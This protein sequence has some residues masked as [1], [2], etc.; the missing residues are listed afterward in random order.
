MQRRVIS[1]ALFA[2]GTAAAL[3]PGASCG[4]ASVVPPVRA[5]HETQGAVDVRWYGAV[6]DGA[7]D[8]TDAVA[9]ALA[10]ASKAGLTLV[11][12]AGFTFRITRYLE[13][14]SNTNLYLLGTIRLTNRVAGLYANGATNIGIFGQGLGRLEDPAVGANYRWNDFHSPLA[15]AIHLRS[16]RNVLIDRLNISHCQ[17]GILISNA[18]SNSSAIG[19]LAL[20]Q[21]NPAN[22]TV[23]N[24]NI[25]FCEMGGICS[26][27][28]EDTR[29]I[30][31]YVYR[32]GD[33]GIWMMGARD[34]EVIGNHR[35]SPYAVPA[36]V[37]AYGRN[38]AAHPAG[39]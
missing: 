15:P 32:C 37:A 25:Q 10:S 33:G 20:T 23:E 17:Q 31:N 9:A 16:T 1:R 6:G 21:A 36:A 14:L 22:C 39:V 5:G 8:D 24:C 35:V 28:A 18:S 26:F 3:F 12:P 30:G 11:F 29:Y 13:I 4:G 7:A 19:A 27:N 2:S 38:N 34:S